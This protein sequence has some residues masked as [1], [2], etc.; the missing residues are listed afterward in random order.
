MNDRFAKAFGEIASYNGH[1]EWLWD[2]ADKM[3]L[4]ERGAFFSPDVMNVEPLSDRHALLMMLFSAFG[5]WGISIRVGW[6][7]D[8]K[9]A[10]DFIDEATERYAEWRKDGVPL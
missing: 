5:N 1:E 9:A 4:S 7:E 6:I 3:R 2:L 8:T 10:A